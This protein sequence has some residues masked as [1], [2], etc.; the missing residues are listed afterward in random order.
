MNKQELLSVIDTSLEILRD[1]NRDHLYFYKELK[2]LRFDV[3]ISNEKIID[4]REKQLREIIKNY[5]DQNFES[6]NDFPLWFNMIVKMVI[7]FYDHNKIRKEI[8]DGREK[9]KK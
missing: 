6:I 1:N 3:K 2:S 9:I 4:V 8:K 5:K 7:G